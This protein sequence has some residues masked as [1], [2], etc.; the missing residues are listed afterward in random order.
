MKETGRHANDFARKEVNRII[1]RALWKIG[2]AHSGRRGAADSGEAA[3]AR[4]P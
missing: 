2:D 1:L 4:R 3:G